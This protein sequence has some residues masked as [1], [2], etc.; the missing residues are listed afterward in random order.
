MKP[1][2]DFSPDT[3]R[4]VD[5]VL[6]D[7]DDTL[8]LDGRLP[9]ASYAA[10]EDLTKAGL[11]C[12]VVTGRPGGW[13]D[14]M[15][16]FWPIAGVVGENGAFYY[17]Y[18]HERRQMLRVYE[19]D[20]STRA[21]NMSRLESL[22]EEAQAQFPGFDISADQAFRVSDLA[23]D[24]CEDVAPQKMEDVERLRDLF[25]AGGATAKISSIHVNAWFGDFDKLSMSQR[26]FQEVLGTTLS[27][28]LPRTIYVGDSPNDEPMFKAFPHSIGVANVEAFVNQMTSPPNW[29]T[30]AEGGHGFREI[31]DLL[32][33]HR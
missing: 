32:L 7:M 17:R 22:Y 31:A 1:F 4:D 11:H 15:A 14:M 24:F 29:V 3:A 20:L 9:G 12:I 5:F 10:L 30:S 6:C 27:E 19:Q 26:F 13:C 8:T 2:A 28:A 33:R 25:E 23:I 18:D 21:A 16:R